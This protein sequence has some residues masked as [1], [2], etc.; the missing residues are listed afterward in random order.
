MRNSISRDLSIRLS[1]MIL[2]IGSVIGISYSLYS[3]NTFKK[4]FERDNTAQTQNISSMLILQL[5]LFDLETIGELCQHLLSSANITGIQVT[6][7]DHTEIFNG[8]DLTREHIS[9]HHRQLRHKDKDVGH[10]TIGFSTA[11]LYQHANS[12]RNVGIAILLSVIFSSF[13]LVNFLLKK[14][15]GYPLDQLRDSMHQLSE[16]N[17]EEAELKNQKKEIQQ[18]I[19]SFNILVEKLKQRDSEIFEKNSRLEIEV[20]ERI[21]ANSIFKALAE[22]PIGTNSQDIYNS[23][24]SKTCE[25]FNCETAVLGIMTD[26]S[27]VAKILTLIQQ[28]EF[29]D[30]SAMDISKNPCEQVLQAGYFECSEDIDKK[31]PERNYLIDGEK[32]TSFIGIALKNNQGEHIGFLSAISRKP[33]TIPKQGREILDILQSLAVAELERARLQDENTNIEYRLRQA[34]K[35]EAIG[36]LAGGIAHDF[37]NILTAIMGYAEMA[38]EEATP[39]S[40]LAEDLDNVLDSCERAKELV[41]QILT[42][43]RQS[44]AKKAVFQP[45]TIV[46]EAVKMLRSSIPATIEIKNNIDSQTNF[47]HGDPTQINQIMLNLCTNA[48]H[49][50]EQSGGTINISLQNREI[51]EATQDLSAG[52]YVELSI[53][54]TGQGIS[55]DL[56]SRIFEP[57]F[58]TKDMGKGTGMGLAIIHGIVKDYGGSITVN[59]SKGEGT[60][61]RVFFPA[62]EEEAIDNK[63]NTS[64]I[65]AGTERILFVDDEKVLANMGGVLLSR[66]GYKVTTE[67]DSPKALEQFSKSP[68]SYDL[69]I[70]DQ[71][72]PNLTGADLAKQAL[73]IR[74]DLPIILCTGYSTI[75]SAEEA[76]EIGIKEFLLKP[77]SRKMLA[78][79][80]RTV[81]DK[82]K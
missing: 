62:A 43:S 28:G 76:S 74:P 41:K 32:V 3:T 52:S 34:Q 2:V 8:G 7:V 79:S 31:F 69:I 26:S 30:T 64:L 36:T 14:H 48:F 46:K 37:N 80:V 38:R 58:T 59:S 60:T 63:L 44:D 73:A 18:I 10:L 16:G 1:L 33:I 57:Y 39:K 22:A 27:S 20:S 6:D 65:E 68:Y 67:T 12:I 72:M 47:I 82:D 24:V 49:A 50:M 77:V 42:F 40:E 21:K 51:I 61:I 78:A 53:K 5:W 9:I 70:T 75:I 54:D 15:L 25:V 71:T 17:F 55:P 35:M 4:N 45:A 11:P 19:G 13:I 29:Q 81:L 56:Q 66:L 23:I